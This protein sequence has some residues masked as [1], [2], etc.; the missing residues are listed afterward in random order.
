M[1]VC[2]LLPVSAGCTSTDI[3]VE[4]DRTRLVILPKEHVKL[5]EK[6]K[7]GEGKSKA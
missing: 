6:G 2:F 4:S 5:I 3:R 1:V 7:G